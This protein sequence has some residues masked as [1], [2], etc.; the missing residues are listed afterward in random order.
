ME[1]TPPTGAEVLTEPSGVTALSVWCPTCRRRPGDKC[2]TGAPRV[3]GG[4][5]L[6]S[7][8]RDPHYARVEL[9][10]IRGGITR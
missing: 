7:P 10:R 8:T 4:A 2:L 5:V 3:V 1:M 6:P 9:A